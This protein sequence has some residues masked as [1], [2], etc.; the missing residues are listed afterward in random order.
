MRRLLALTLLLLGT[1]RAQPY[2]FQ[3]LG[4]TWS[5]SL[6]PIPCK[7]YRSRAADFMWPSFDGPKL[8]LVFHLAPQGAS[9]EEELDF[10]F[11][12]TLKPLAI[13]A[14]KGY[15]LAQGPGFCAAF[16]HTG[17]G[18]VFIGARSRSKPPL[19]DRRLEQVVMELIRSA[20]R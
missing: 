19:P 1:G 12:E 15:S 5:C 7:S 20:Y 13:R 6:D 16:V 11:G 8:N 4:S 18:R 14:P 17:R 9:F 2:S 3:A 10:A